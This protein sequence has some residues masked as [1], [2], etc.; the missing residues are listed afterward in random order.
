MDGVIKGVTDDLDAFVLGN[1]DARTLSRYKQADQVYAQEARKLTKSRLKTVLDRGDV[2]PELVN[3]LLFSSSPSEVK[4]LFNNLDST[5]RQNARLSLYRRALDNSTKNGEISPQRFVSE[6]GKL[7]GN[8]NTFFRGDAKAE[9]NGLKRLLETTGR[10][11]ESAVVGPTGQALQIPAT[12]AVLAGAAVGNPAAIGTVL[13]A[14]TIG[15]AARV[16]ESA[17]VRNMLIQLGKAP[18]RS[19]LEADLKKSIPLVLAEANRGI[20]QEEQAL[21]SS[22]DSSK[23]DK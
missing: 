17:G 22:F 5:G 15:L 10:A 7:E 18:K 4:L 8:F 6:L 11:G 21:R 14:S 13:G 9:L 2:K 1:S 12:T 19:T 23:V 3:N 16:Y 20:E